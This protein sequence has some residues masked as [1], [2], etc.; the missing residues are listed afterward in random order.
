M[1]IHVIV[2]NI[3]KTILD[4]VHGIGPS[5][6]AVMSKYENRK[7][8]SPSIH[9]ITHPKCPSWIIDLLHA[10]PD[11]CA[12]KANDLDNEAAR[13]RRHAEALRAEADE[14]ILKA[15]QYNSKAEEFRTMHSPPQNAP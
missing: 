4:T 11:W 12:C 9:N 14:M 15:D 10:D 5:S 1:R 8:L 13:K 7:D 6:D 3:S 2:D